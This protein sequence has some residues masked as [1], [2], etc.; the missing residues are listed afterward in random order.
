MALTLGFHAKFPV[1]HDSY[2]ASISLLVQDDILDG[3]WEGAL[4]DGRFAFEQGLVSS[5]LGAMVSVPVTSHQ[6]QGRSSP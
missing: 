5:K 6:G 3:D 1:C 2:L 4:Q